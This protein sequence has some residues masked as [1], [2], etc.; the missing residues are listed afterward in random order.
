MIEGAAGVPACGRRGRQTVPR[1]A[2][3]PELVERGTRA[4]TASRRSSSRRSR[5]T[6]TNVYWGRGA[7]AALDGWALPQSAVG[8]PRLH[9]RPRLC[10]LSAASK[11][12]LRRIESKVVEVDVTPRA[13]GLIVHNP[14]HDFPPLMRP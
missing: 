11:H 3:D 5:G 2:R 9:S 6:T 1:Q 14:N 13:A 4:A 8:A 7:L 10:V 12:R